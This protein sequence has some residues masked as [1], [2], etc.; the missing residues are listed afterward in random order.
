VV[1]LSLVAY[2][3]AA[4]V[5]KPT[6]EG[7]AVLPVATYAPGPPSGSFCAGQTINGISFPTPSQPVEGFSSVLS[8][9]TPG[10]FLAMPDNGVGAKANSRDF[11]LRA[12][13]IEPDFK[14]SKGGTG[15][16]TVKDF[17]QFRDP[18]GIIGF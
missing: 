10:E 4:S 16:V 9:R 3:A 17:I 14:T 18:N 8:G 15:A 6:L 2:P 12:Y 5:P 13:Y 7:R 1:P 11:R